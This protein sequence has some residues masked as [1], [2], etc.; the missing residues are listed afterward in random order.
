MLNII[1]NIFENDNFIVCDKPSA[2]LSVPARERNDVRPCLGLELQKMRDEEASIRN[3]YPTKIITKQ[4]DKDKLEA[5]RQRREALQIPEASMGIAPPGMPT[6]TAPPTPQ[7]YM[8]EATQTPQWQI[9]PESLPSGTGVFMGQAPIAATAPTAVTPPN[10]GPQMAAPI[11]TAAPQV[12]LTIPS[13]ISPATPRRRVWNAR[14]G[15]L[16]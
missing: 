3:R 7:I 4:E 5:I 9:Q 13:G 15:K 16:E 10:M 2:V 8:G 12:G 11:P 6:R 14:T 1:F